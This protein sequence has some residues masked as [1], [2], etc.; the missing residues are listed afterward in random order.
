MKFSSFVLGLVIS[1]GPNG[2]DGIYH[3]LANLKNGHYQWSSRFS[4]NILE[5][6]IYYDKKTHKTWVVSSGS[7]LLVL[8]GLDQFFEPVISFEMV[9]FGGRSY[10]IKITCHDVSAYEQSVARRWEKFRLLCLKPKIS[11]PNIPPSHPQ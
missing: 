4:R 5:N 10:N 3:K 7:N 8:R 9:S 6:S 11:R 2:F 1:N